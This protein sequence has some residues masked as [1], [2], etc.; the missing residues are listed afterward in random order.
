MKSLLL[1]NIYGGGT[2]VEVTRQ[3]VELVFV[4]LLLHRFWSRIQAVSIVW[5]VPLPDAPS[6]QHH[7]APPPFY[8]LIQIVSV[9]KVDMLH[10]K[11]LS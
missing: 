11:N 9:L 3:C 1:L 10:V 7:L 2:Y 4:L 6:C 8:F 5:Q